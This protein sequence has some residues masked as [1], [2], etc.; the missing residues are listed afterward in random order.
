MDQVMKQLIKKCYPGIPSDM[1][2]H[3][4]QPEEQFEEGAVEVPPYF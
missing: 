1:V 3:I 4:V 2:S